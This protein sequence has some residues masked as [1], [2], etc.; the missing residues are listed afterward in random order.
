MAKIRSAQTSFV[1]G[2]LDPALIV[3]TD[4]DTFFKGGSALTNINVITQGGIERRWGLKYIVGT[5]G[6]N[7]VKKAPFEFNNE[8]KYLFVFSAGQLDAYA[9]DVL[10]DTLTTAPISSITEAMLPDLKWTQSADT[11][12]LFHPDL[13]TIKITRTGAATF[14]ATAVAFSGIPTYDYGSGAEPVISASRGWPVSGSFHQARL[15]L[16]GLKGRPQTTLMSQVG[17]FENLAEGTG[18]D[19][20]GINITINSGQ[21]NPIRSCYSGR[22]FQIFTEGGE[23]YIPSGLDS[24]PITPTN[25]TII[26][27]TGHGVTNLQPISVDGATLFYDGKDLREFVFKDIELSYVAESLSIMST[28]IINSCVSMALRRTVESSNANY[29]YMV[30]A[31]GTVGVLN[32]LRGQGITAWTKY[33]TLGE[34]EDVAVVG[35]DVYFTVKRSVNGAD[36][37]YIER[38]DEAYKTDAAIQ[39]TS[40]SATD[41]WSGLS[42]LEGEE[43]KAVGD[44]FMMDNVTVASGA[45]TTSKSVSDTEFGMDFAFFVKT[46]PFDAVVEG[47]T[48]TA[49]YKRKVSVRLNL[50][51]TRNILVDGF[52]PA[53]TPIADVFSGVPSYINGWRRVNLSGIDRDA[54][55]EI[56]QDQ[57]LEFKMF[58]MV[59]EV[60]F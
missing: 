23:F 11:M 7:P 25:I 57:P 15:V 26:R 43:V 41:S 53:S 52:R 6:N 60:K 36:V 12:Y 24:A 28:S 29:V 46:M 49:E 58:G 1:A 14:T 50:E 20:E 9:D 4:L 38:L 27:Q 56:T 30:N 10:V 34:F 8:Q 39:Q 22:H 33:T 31:D 5:P 32:T 48:L 59:L 3:R 35:G 44:N 16:C 13:Q 2:Q 17:D 18:L 51:N 37:R 42:H 21:A 45:V 55:V 40:G 19:D 54:Q 47:G